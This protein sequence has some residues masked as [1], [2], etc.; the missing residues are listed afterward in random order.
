MI[1]PTISELALLGVADAG[2]PNRERIIIRP[3][4][5][6]NMAEFFLALGFRQPSGMIVPI[7][8]LVFW[9][10]KIQLVP[11]GWFIVYTGPGKPEVS[12]VPNTGETAYTYH[13]G[14][15]Q[16]VFIHPDLVPVLFSLG[17]ILIGPP[18]LTQHRPALPGKP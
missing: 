2:V 14:R 5:S 16:T 8:D 9:F 3:T 1:L 18:I 6:I 12:N 11:P 13:W 10:P 15:P 4:E 17:G 7:P